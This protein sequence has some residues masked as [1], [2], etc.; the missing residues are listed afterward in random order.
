MEAVEAE[1]DA[2]DKETEITKDRVT[3]QT[4]EEDAEEEDATKREETT[5]TTEREVRETDKET[6]KGTTAVAVVAVAVVVEVVRTG[7]NNNNTSR[8]TY[9][10]INVIIC[11]PFLFFSP[12]TQ[13]RKQNLFLSSSFS[14]Y[15]N[16]R[17]YYFMSSFCC[18]SRKEDERDGE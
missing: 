13:Y 12:P 6:D 5:I 4:E 8:R 9:S 15:R 14:H 17:N 1:A 3:N 11:S 10:Y 16:Q 7:T 18:W 2:T